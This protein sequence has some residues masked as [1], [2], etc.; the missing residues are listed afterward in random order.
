MQNN[1]S[2]LSIHGR[3][4]KLYRG[5]NFPIYPSTTFAV[6]KSDDY[7][8]FI[9]DEEEF[10]IYSRYSNPTVRNVEEKLAALENSEAATLFSSGMAAITTSILA[11]TKSGD[12]IVALR[13]LYG[14]TYRFLRDIAPR[15]GIETHFVE[16][17]ELYA[18]DTKYPDAKIVY[19]ETPIN[20][21][22][23]CVSI[24]KVVKA[25][26]KTGAL[27]FV[28]NTF[29]SPINQN[30]LDL[31]VDV[32]LHSATKYIGGH[33]DIMAGAAVASKKLTREIREGLKAFG[34]CIN[35]IDAYMLD[36][37]L[38]TL[39]VRIEQ[40]NRS[41]QRLAE[42]FMRQRKV[43]RVLYPGLPSSKCYNTAKRQM[44]GFGGMLCIE[45]GNLDEGKR[46]CDSLEVAL[47]ATSLG[48]VET[49]V[50]IPVLTSHIKMS[51]E[52]LKAARVTEGMVRISVGIED[53]DDLMLDFKKA[54]EKIK[55]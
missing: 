25:A 39:K 32:V 36:R 40:Q 21:T 4:D 34:G 1:K 6:E 35:P 22:T 45:L 27:T 17:S 33:S 38:K 26:R 9:G 8:K 10:Y 20:P 12:H 41:A 51:P 46:F 30:P 44:T 15:F 47:N 54:L 14:M 50:S 52:E 3:K 37:S 16:E 18:V 23:E 19:F 42:F 48:G 31:G 55:A 5:A 53:T 2:T 49:L 7:D 28:D 29:A 43:K 13:R 24:R 11:F